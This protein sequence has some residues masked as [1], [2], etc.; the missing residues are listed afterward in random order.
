MKRLLIAGF[1]AGL[2]MSGPA[3]AADVAARPILK[4]PEP[5]V[6]SW[7]GI[8]FGGHAGCGS[9]G[10]PVLTAF[11]TM[12]VDHFDHHTENATGCFSGGQVG[13][14]YQFAGGFVIGILGELSWGKISSFN[15]SIGDFGLSV[16]S[17][18]SKLTSMGTARARIGY[19]VNGGLPLVGGLS[20]MPYVTG[21]WAWGGSTVSSQV[22]TLLNPFSSGTA[23]LGGWT[24]GGG[25]EYAI[26]PSLSWKA[27]YLYTR[28]N[29]ATYLATID[30]DIGITPGLTLDRMNL[31]TFKTGLNLRLGGGRF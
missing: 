1:A 15:Q 8:Y 9:A 4:A 12:D 2:L 10:A 23:S 11:N 29:A 17:W 3:I 26:T 5:S 14:D 28:Y 20:W 22:S 30:D 7:S 19:A 21:G 24:V 16:T 25:L 31:S 13:A 27:E 6:F 18:E